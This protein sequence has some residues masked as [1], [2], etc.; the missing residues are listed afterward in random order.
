[1]INVCPSTVSWCASLR[2]QPWR[3]SS[4]SSLR[5]NAIG[6]S[7]TQHVLLSLILSLLSCVLVGLR[8]VLPCSL[9][10]R[11]KSPKR[12]PEKCCLGNRRTEIWLWKSRVDEVVKEMRRYC[13]VFTKLK[14]QK[15]C[16]QAKV[17][18]DSAKKLA[19]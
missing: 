4:A 2:I 19:K 6:N 17:K 12:W 11:F 18:Y 15:L 16:D 9:L 3:E 13:K 14:R 8:Q 1:M 10:K 5:I 7:Q